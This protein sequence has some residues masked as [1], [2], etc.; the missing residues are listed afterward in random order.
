M[1]SQNVHLLEQYSHLEYLLLGDLRDL[2]EEQ[3]DAENR[4]WLVAVLEVLLDMLPRSFTLARE[5]G[6]LEFVRDQHPNWER[7]IEHLE[8]DHD[9]LYVQL[10]HLHERV[11]A[12]E[13]LGPIARELRGDLGAWMDSLVSHHHAETRLLQVAANLDIGAGD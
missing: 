13:W 11:S 7:Q 12:N 4:R 5:D 3:P 2:L 10:R 8:R 9:R 6:Y 1:N